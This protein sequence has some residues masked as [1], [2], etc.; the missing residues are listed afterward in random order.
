MPTK[1]NDFL[2][3][4]SKREPERGKM[5]A[6]KYPAKNRENVEKRNI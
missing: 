5:W 4:E 2:I 1:R 6:K 3:K